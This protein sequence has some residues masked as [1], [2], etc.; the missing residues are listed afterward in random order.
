VHIGTQP[1]G[2]DIYRGGQRVGTT[3]W[4]FDE[5]I[6]S[7]FK[8]VLKCQGFKDEEIN[9]WVNDHGNEYLYTPEKSS[10]R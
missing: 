7:Y 5:P 9:F 10:R 3:P 4:H 1:S 6:G 8:A 2:F